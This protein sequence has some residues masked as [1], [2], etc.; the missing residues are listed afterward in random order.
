[1][2]RVRRYFIFQ[3]KT[4]DLQN[5]LDNLPEGDEAVSVANMLEKPGY[6]M[7]M[8]K[9]ARTSLAVKRRLVAKSTGQPR[10]KKK[11]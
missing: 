1:M 9:K 5:T 7:L 11:S 4:D 2:P 10:R 8:V 6:V 3:V